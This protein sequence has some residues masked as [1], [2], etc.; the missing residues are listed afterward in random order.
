MRKK[1]VHITEKE[2]IKRQHRYVEIW[3][4]VSEHHAQ[5]KKELSSGHL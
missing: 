4:D 2:S 3:C 5:I 1:H